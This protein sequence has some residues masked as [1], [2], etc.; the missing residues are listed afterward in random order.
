MGLYLQGSMHVI[1]TFPLEHGANARAPHPQRDIGGQPRPQD[2][3]NTPNPPLHSSQETATQPATHPSPPEN[4]G[5][6]KHTATGIRQPQRDPTQDT[7]PAN[8]QRR[9][10]Q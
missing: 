5:P 10:P 7:M 9:T 4:R 8:A 3:G 6:P 2:M 1:P